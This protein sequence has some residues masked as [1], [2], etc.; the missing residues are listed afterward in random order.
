MRL[1]TSQGTRNDALLRCVCDPTNTV[2]DCVYVEGLP[3]SGLPKVSLCSITDSLKMPSIGVLSS[4]ISPTVCLVRA[5]GPVDYPDPLTPGDK[6]WVS[7]S[8]RLTSVPP[9]P[10]TPSWYLQMMGVALTST[11]FLTQLSLPVRRVSISI[12][13]QKAIRVGYDG[14]LEEFNPSESERFGIPLTGAYNGVNRD[15][16]IPE[17]I[18]SDA[19]ASLR[20]Y[21]NGQ[22]LLH[23]VGND[24]VVTESGGAG[25]GYDTVIVAVPPQSYESL[26]ADYRTY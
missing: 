20:V 9:T 24:Y 21:L 8:G 14:L 4:K 23:G 26:I 13:A 3:A 15:F 16:T 2:G 7:S 5:G 19:S 10:F 1:Q 18:L 6:Y 12:P 17:L 22:R 11:T 25:T